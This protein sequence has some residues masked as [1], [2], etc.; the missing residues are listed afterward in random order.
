M[1]DSPE[2]YSWLAYE[3]RNLLL[4]CERCDALK[5]NYFPVHGVRAEP[6]GSWNDAQRTEHPLLLDPS[7]DEPY[8]HLC[9]NSHG[10]IAHLSEKG[11]VTI[12]V[13]GLE[14]PEL[15]NRRGA[16]FAGIVALLS[17]TASDTDE[18]LNRAMSDDAEFAGVVSLGNPPIFRAR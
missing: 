3:W 16:H 13:L 2:H 12:A 11:M 15:L 6:L 1:P 5:R 7:I 10:S 9:V 18:M 8:R 4:L 17:D 14:R